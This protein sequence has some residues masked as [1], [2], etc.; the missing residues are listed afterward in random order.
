MDDKA[1]RAIEK[2]V[3]KSRDVVVGSVDD[4]GCPNAKLMFKCKHDGLKTFY[5]STNTSSVRAGQFLKRPEACIYFFNQ[6][7]FHGLMLTGKMRVLT[8]DESKRML[9]RPGDE[10]Y[11]PLGP[12]DPDYCVLRFD[13]EKGNYYHAL[14]KVLFDVAEL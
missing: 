1:I 5:F 13:A 3:D 4:E 10:K 14:N 12:A 8:D 7:F 2:L 9:W 6:T 11:Y